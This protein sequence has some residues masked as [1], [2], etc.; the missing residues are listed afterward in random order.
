MSTQQLSRKSP[1]PLGGCPCP[2][3]SLSLDCCEMEVNRP[4]SSRFQTFFKKIRGKGA[5]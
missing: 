5:R 3:G 2:D 1:N 4:R